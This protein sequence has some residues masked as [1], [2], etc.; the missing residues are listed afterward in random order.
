[1]DGTAIALRFVKLQ[2]DD[3]ASALAFWQSAF[4]FEVQATYDEPGFLEHV[5]AI[6]GENGGLSLMLVQPKPAARLEQGTAHGPLGFMCAD[7][8][9]ALQ[10]A[11]AAGA[12]VTMPVTQVAPGVQV[13]LLESPQGHAVELVQLD[14]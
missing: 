5:L 10:R 9:A 7:I 6:A 1:M 2:V 8:S 14:T 11:L 13:C 3:M 12:R 4:G